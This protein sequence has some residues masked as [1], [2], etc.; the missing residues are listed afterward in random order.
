MRSR[1]AAVLVAVLALSL[2][3]V[4][5]AQRAT[6]EVNGT[7]TDTSGG[8]VPSAMVKL[9]NQATGIET[10]RSTNESGV[11]LFVNVQPGAYLVHVSKSGFRDDELKGVVVGVNQAPPPMWRSRSAASRRHWKSMPRLLSFRAVIRQ[12]R[13][14][15]HA[16]TLQ[17]VHNGD[18][19]RL[20]AG[21]L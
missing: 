2:A 8:A 11:Y 20:A 18:E 5:R 13:V 4:V 10:V 7:V 19:G 9:T 14:H 16:V 21:L 6:G 17:R 1:I 15:G 12:N 3:P